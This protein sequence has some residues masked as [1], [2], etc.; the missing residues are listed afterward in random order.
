MNSFSGE[1]PSEISNLNSLQVLDLAENNLTGRIPESLRDLEAMANR[2]NV[3]Q[4]LLYGHCRGSYYE[5]GLTINTQGQSLR[6]TKTLSLVI[7]ID[8]SSNSLHGD[9]PTQ[10]TKLSGLVLLNLSR[11]HINGEIPANISSLNQLASLDLSTNNLSGEIPPSISSLSFLGHLN[12]SNNNLSGTIP[13]RDQIS[14]FDASS[15]GGNPGVCGSPLDVKCQGEDSD[16]E[17]GE[18]EDE[19]GDVDGF[20]DRWFNLFV[21]VGYAAGILIPMLVLAVSKPWRNYYFAFVD[22][23]VDR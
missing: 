3:I 15:F 18:V 8:L 1:I 2:Q 16:K 20:I 22:R 7:G 9:F 12:L 6:F 21:G 19:G 4:Y 17:G 10:L 14:T 13:Y 11:N 5:E 23:I